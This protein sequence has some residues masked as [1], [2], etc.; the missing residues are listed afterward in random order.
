MIYAY[1]KYM[2]KRNWVFRFENDKCADIETVSSYL[3]KYPAN[4]PSVFHVETTW[5]RTF[6]R[7]FNVEYTWSVCRVCPGITDLFLHYDN[8]RGFYL[9]HFPKSGLL[10][11]N[12]LCEWQFFI[13]ISSLL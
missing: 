5:K 2:I 8:R 12:C 9:K 3:G 1:S 11:T 4:T 13:E 6:P 10:Q 7:R